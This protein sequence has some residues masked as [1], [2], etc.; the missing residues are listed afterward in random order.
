MG[1]DGRSLDADD[2]LPLSVSTPLLVSVHAGTQ[3]LV[4]FP[5]PKLS[6]EIQ[7]ALREKSAECVLLENCW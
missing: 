2:A 4:N 7:E 6:V 1:A 3:E 5:P